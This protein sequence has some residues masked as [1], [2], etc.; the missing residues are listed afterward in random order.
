MLLDHARCPEATE[1]KGTNKIIG[2][3]VHNYLLKVDQM[4]KEGK[5]KYG[6]GEV[7]RLTV[8]HDDWCGIYKRKECNCN[9]DL[10][11]EAKS[12]ASVNQ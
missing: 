12:A 1:R 10:A 8:L 11:L 3:R 2:A 7:N 9:P 4:L 5:I 6:N